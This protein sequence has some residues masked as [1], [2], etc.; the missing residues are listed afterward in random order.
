MTLPERDAHLMPEELAAI[1]GRVHK[2]IK[3]RELAALHKLEQMLRVRMPEQ[4]ATWKIEN[5]FDRTEI[6]VERHGE[7]L[8]RLYAGFDPEPFCTGLYNARQPPTPEEFT[9][10]LKA[11]VKRLRLNI[12]LLQPLPRQPPA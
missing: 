4:Q 6:R 1:R 10:G 3:V 11:E 8:R 12:F 2:L 5:V 9:L 7:T